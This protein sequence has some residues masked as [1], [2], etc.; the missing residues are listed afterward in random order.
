MLLKFVHFEVSINGKDLIGQFIKA[1]PKLVTLDVFKRGNED[2]L[3]QYSQVPCNEVALDVS[4][5]GKDNKEAHLLHA[6]LKLV[7]F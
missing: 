2:K 5:N 7:I 3:V 4:I 6:A 1:E